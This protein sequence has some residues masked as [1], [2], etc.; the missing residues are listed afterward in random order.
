[1]SGFPPPSFYSIWETGSKCPHEINCFKDLD[2]GM[3]YAKIV[4][5]PVMIDFTGWSCVNCRKMEENIWIEPEV[6]QLLKED[7]VLISLY[8]DDKS[9]LP[10]K[11][12]KLSECTG[13]KIKTIG[14]KWSEFQACTF[15]TNSQPY[16]VLMG[17]DEKLLNTPKGYTPD[18]E[19][20]IEFLQEGLDAFRNGS[21]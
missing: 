20:Y 9:N 21:S 18:K 1:M 4:E 2:E 16:Y 10:E 14:N 8:V 7:Y 19:K 15:Q 5:K 6:L 3:A 11:E 17:P 13:K 12:Q